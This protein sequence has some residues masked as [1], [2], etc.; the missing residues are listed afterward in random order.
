MSIYRNV[1]TVLS[2]TEETDEAQAGSTY[3]VLPPDGDSIAD[4]R[5]RRG[6]CF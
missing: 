2:V 4:S 1:K 6:V 3:L 5:M